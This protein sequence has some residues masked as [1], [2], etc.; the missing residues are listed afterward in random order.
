MISDLKFKFG[1]HGGSVNLIMNGTLYVDN[2]F[3][4]MTP[5]PGVAM[6]V[7]PS[8]PLGNVQLSG[9]IDPF[10]FSFPCPALFPTFRYTAVVGGGQELWIDDIEFT[11]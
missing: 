8:L 2:N 7:T 4:S 5:P 10:Y 6:T 1:D 3:K 9:S 11:Q